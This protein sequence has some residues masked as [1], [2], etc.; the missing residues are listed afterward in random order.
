MHYTVFL[1]SVGAEAI[2]RCRTTGADLQA[3]RL[4][5]CPHDLVNVDVQPLGAVLA[6]VIDVGQPLRNDGWHP[7]RAPVVVDPETA[8][9]RSNR[10]DDAWRT[11]EPELGGLMGEVV[12]GDID[13]VRGLYAHASANHEWVVSYL[14]APDDPNL[15]ERSFVPTADVVG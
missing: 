1:A 7:Q 10:L 8:M 13:A 9:A 3:S 11:A 15:A 4:V 12:G 6:E 14:S 2:E 5:S